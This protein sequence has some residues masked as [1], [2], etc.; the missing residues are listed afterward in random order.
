MKLFKIK[1]SFLPLV[2]FFSAFLLFRAAPVAYGGSQARDRIG[3]AAANLHHSHS[4]M[5]SEPDRDLH[6]SSWQCRIL[7]SLSEARD[8]PFTLIN[9]SQMCFC[10][11]SR[12]TPELPFFF[13]IF[14]HHCTAN[15][16]G[17]Y[18]VSLVLI[19]FYFLYNFKY[20]KVY[21]HRPQEMGRSHRTVSLPI[22]KSCIFW[23]SVL[24]EKLKFT[25]AVLCKI[26][27]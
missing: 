26:L 22:K 3:A 4:N 5:G 21:F 16:I 25:L 13:S 14:L 17:K 12:G 18:E 1:S 10:C 9:T 2:S 8:G 24:E 15:I 7:N 27:T 11:A 19:L 23:E 6:H 20:I